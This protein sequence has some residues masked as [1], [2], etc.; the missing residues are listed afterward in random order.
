MKLSNIY[1]CFCDE[2]RLRILHLL[3]HGPLC[4]CHFQR[5]LG[6][7]QVS[8]SKR[9]AYLRE[10][11]LVRATRHEQWMIYQ[12]P[13][14]ISKELALQLGCL[15]ECVE[16]YIVFKRDLERLKALKT[17]CGWVEAAASS[18]KKGNC[19]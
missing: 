11:G 3:T 1:Q 9:L 5:I 2:T 6:V 19:C 17:E 7:T 12:L 16:S 14:R 4:V 15:R 13:K 10:H 8:I 18:G